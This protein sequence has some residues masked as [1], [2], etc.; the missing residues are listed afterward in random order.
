[1]KQIWMRTGI[2]I[3]MTDDEVTAI[4]EGDYTARLDALRKILDEGRF[5]WDGDSYIPEECIQAFNKKYGTQY[6]DGEYEF[7][8]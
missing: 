7:D 1:M 5:A 6:S 4:L 3:N 2:I 8:L